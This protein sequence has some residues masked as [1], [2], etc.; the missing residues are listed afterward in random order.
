M[1]T[2]ATLASLLEELE[3]VLFVLFAFDGGQIMTALSPR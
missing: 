3:S 2:A 1:G